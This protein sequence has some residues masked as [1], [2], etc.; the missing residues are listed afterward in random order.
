MLSQLF[1]RFPNFLLPG[2][3]VHIL[4]KRGIFAEVLPIVDAPKLFTH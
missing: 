3:K 1:S 2:R 4:A